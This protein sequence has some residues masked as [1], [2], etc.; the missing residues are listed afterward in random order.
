M[1]PTRRGDHRTL[2][3][4]FFVFTPVQYL[5]VG[6]GQAFVEPE[7]VIITWLAMLFLDGYYL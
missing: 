7:G 5:L 2:F 1:T 4:V 3:W 6:V